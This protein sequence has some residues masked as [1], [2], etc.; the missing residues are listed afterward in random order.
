MNKILAVAL[1]A[2]ACKCTTPYNKALQRCITKCTPSVVARVDYNFN[3]NRYDKCVCNTHLL[4]KE[5]EDEVE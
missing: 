2:V 1:L 5:L 4:E 3:N